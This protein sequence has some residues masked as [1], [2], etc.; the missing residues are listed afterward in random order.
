MKHKPCTLGGGTGAATIVQIHLH[1]KR[2]ADSLEINTGPKL[3]GQCQWIVYFGVNFC[4]F[5]F[6]LRE[7]QKKILPFFLLHASFFVPIPQMFHKKQSVIHAYD[8]DT[9]D[10]DCCFF[11]TLDVCCLFLIVI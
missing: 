1:F 2:V 10:T 11:T 8:L 9:T 5:H 6:F 4:V 3:F 7:I